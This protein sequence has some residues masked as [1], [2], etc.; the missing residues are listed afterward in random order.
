MAAEPKL[1]LFVVDQTNK[2]LISQFYLY[3]ELKYEDINSQ[4][5]GKETRESPLCGGNI[6]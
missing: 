6:K 1:V 4:T 5:D 3:K 2:L